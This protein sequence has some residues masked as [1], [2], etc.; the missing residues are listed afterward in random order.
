MPR[1]CRSITR[2]RSTLKVVPAVRGGDPAE[3]LGNA[4]LVAHRHGQ[5]ADARSVQMYDGMSRR[6][7]HPGGPD[8]GLAEGG[9]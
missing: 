1:T 5:R 3:V 7:I 4:V 2:G 6:Q 9:G 8:I